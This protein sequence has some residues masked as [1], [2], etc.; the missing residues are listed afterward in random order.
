MF[1]VRKTVDEARGGVGPSKL[2]KPAQKKRLADKEGS[3]CPNSVL[4]ACDEEAIGK[5]VNF[6][7]RA[8]I[9]L[10]KGKN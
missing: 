2:Q 6:G 4:G 1:K 7:D 3:V 5:S 8:W 9:E 10:G